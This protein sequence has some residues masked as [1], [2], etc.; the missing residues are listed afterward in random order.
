M[1]PPRHHLDDELRAFVDDEPDAEQARLRHDVDS[2][3]PPSA[4][5]QARA[6]V[7]GRFPRERMDSGVHDVEKLQRLLEAKLAADNAEK[8][9]ALK[10]RAEK[11]EAEL[12]ES[13]EKRN[14][15]IWELVILL[16]VALASAGFGHWIK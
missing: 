4:L 2:R 15:R 10:E 14:A 13:R 7:V 1:T 3:P 6:A 11:A 5:M 8:L 9:L 12:K 16:V